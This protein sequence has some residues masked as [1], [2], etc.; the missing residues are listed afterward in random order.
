MFNNCNKF[1]QDISGWNVS[2]VNTKDNMFDGCTIEETYK[3]KFK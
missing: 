2:K 3:P 1:N